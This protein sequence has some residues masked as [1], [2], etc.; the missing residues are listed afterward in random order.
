MLFVMNSRTLTRSSALGIAV[1][2]LCSVGLDRQSH[3]RSITAY[4]LKPER[5]VFQEED[6]EREYQQ[7]RRWYERGYSL[8]YR[9]AQLGLEPR[10]DV[11]SAPS[12]TSSNEKE[13][14]SK[15]SVRTDTGI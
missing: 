12:T 1:F 2:A 14:C 7:L 15:K 5:A 4:Q 3:K 13:R 6:L 10:Y 8:G 11:G 9:E